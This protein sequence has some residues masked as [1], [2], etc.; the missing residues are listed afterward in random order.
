MSE[1]KTVSQMLINV[2]LSTLTLHEHS[3]IADV[4]MKT[5]WFLK[6]VWEKF[7]VNNLSFFTYVKGP[8]TNIFSC[9]LCA[10]VVFIILFT[11]LLCDN[12]SSL[13]Y[14]PWKGAK[15]NTCQLCD[16]TS[17]ADWLF[18]IINRN[19]DVWRPV[20]FCY[21]CLKKG[22]CLAIAFKT[23]RNKLSELKRRI[24]REKMQ[25]STTMRKILAFRNHSVL[26]E[27][28]FGLSNSGETLEFSF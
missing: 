13:T 25:P 23:W 14:E 15:S 10:W 4:V 18:T 24:A 16:I 19:L 8:K 27:S 3:L 20:S 9:K 5:R 26:D 7:V 12:S 6:I 2:R 17:H 28:H 1:L 22:S 21:Q 11:S